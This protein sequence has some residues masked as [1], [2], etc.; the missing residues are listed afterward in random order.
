MSWE[1]SGQIALKIDQFCGNLTQRFKH[2]F[3]FKQRQSFPLS[4]IPLRNEP[5]AKLFISWLVPSF[6]QHNLGLVVFGILF[7]YF[8][9]ELAR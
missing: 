6:L 9:D 8:C 2:F 4:I 5:M 1:F 7:A 3:F